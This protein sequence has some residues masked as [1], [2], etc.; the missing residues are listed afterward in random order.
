MILYGEIDNLFSAL[1]RQSI[2]YDEKS[3]RVL[4]RNVDES[5]IE[6][7]QVSHGIGLNHHTKRA[8]CILCS[9]PSRGIRRISRVPEHGN[10]TE[11]REHFPEQL[12]PFGG[13]FRVK[14][15]A[16]SKIFAGVCEVVD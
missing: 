12:K 5:N 10:P 1:K 7:L 4:L 13:K 14:N 9:C 3:I 16:A 15:R 6:V 8:S 2:L 11:P